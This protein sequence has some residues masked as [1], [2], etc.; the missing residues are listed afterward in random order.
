MENCAFSQ[1]NYFALPMPI[2]SPSFYWDHCRSSSSYSLLFYIRGRCL[3][4][5]WPIAPIWLLGRIL[6]EAG[7]AGSADTTWW[8]E[9]IIAYSREGALR[10]QTTSTS[11]AT[12]STPICSP[13][14]PSSPSSGSTNSSSPSRNYE[15]KYKDNHS[16]LNSLGNSSNQQCILSGVHRW[17]DG[18]FIQIN[19]FG[20]L[21]SG[22]N[23]EIEISSLLKWRDQAD[24]VQ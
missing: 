21:Y 8:A 12:S 2:T 11:S 5:S 15:S 13:A 24:V 18:E 22:V 23:Q 1:C 6:K 16:G 7:T 17:H 3:P 4:C 10:R 14:T 20:D 19:F 9:T